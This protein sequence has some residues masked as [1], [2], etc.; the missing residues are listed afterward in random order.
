[1]LRILSSSC[2][3]LCVYVYSY[4]F[5]HFFFLKLCDSFIRVKQCNL[6]LKSSL[7][8]KIFTKITLTRMFESL[9]YEMKF[10]ALVISCRKFHL[11]NFLAQFVLSDAKSL[12]RCWKA[13]KHWCAHKE[14]HGTAIQIFRSSIY[15]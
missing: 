9:F 8:W 2:V 4:L 15:I 3:W 10:L 6:Q 11:N 13:W 14:K 12:Q 5:Y 1:M 7:P